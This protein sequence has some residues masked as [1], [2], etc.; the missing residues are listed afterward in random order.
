MLLLEGSTCMLNRGML[1]IDQLL[2]WCGSRS[3]L[4]LPGAQGQRPQAKRTVPL[5]MVIPLIVSTVTRGDHTHI[6]SYHLS[7]DFCAEV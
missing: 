1:W 4:F 7:V 2:V 3:T 5:W 6:G